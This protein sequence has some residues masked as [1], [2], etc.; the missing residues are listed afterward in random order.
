[1]RISRFYCPELTLSDAP[2]S[3]PDNVHRHAIQVLRH[4]VGDV[5]RLFNGQGLECEVTLSEVSKRSSIVGS[6]KHIEVNV[7]SELNITLYQGI[8]RGERMDYAIQK[9]VEL[10]V[11]HIVPVITDRCNVQLGNGR[12]EKREQHWYGVMVSA[13]EQSGRNTVP[14]LSSVT[15]LEDVLADNEISCRLVLDPKAE[16]G[17]RSLPFQKDVAVLI[18]PEGGL[19]DLEVAQVVAA[20]FTAIQFGPRILRT[21]TATAASLAVIQTLWGDLGGKLV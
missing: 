17:F 15:E 11:T 6:F 14:T 3:L 1:M 19:S 4:K 9:A 2:F 13:S 10:G 5:L 7:E 18:G 21:E 16:A 8:S 20:G 12:T